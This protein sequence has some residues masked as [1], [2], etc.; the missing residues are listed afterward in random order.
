MLVEEFRGN[1]QF[2]SL[3]ARLIFVL[4][5]MDMSVDSVRVICTSFG[6][7]AAGRKTVKPTRLATVIV[8]FSRQKREPKGIRVTGDILATCNMRTSAWHEFCI[9]S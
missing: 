2:D 7:M 8:A 3:A 1:C 5:V 9:P 4:R 6:R